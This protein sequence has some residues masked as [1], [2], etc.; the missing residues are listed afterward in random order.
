MRTHSLIIHNL[1][2]SP[3]I[4]LGNHPQQVLH[5]LLAI[6]RRV[7]DDRQ[8]ARGPIDFEDAISVV[9]LVRSGDIV[10]AD[11]GRRN[12]KP[13]SRREELD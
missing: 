7:R 4:S 6:D 10:S 5:L 1:L 3:R 2:Q 12:R 13:S 11:Q 9:A 8:L